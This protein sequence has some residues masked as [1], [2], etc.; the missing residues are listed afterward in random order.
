MEPFG[1]DKLPEVVR[2]LL[3]K[4]EHLEELLLKLHYGQ[5]VT[6]KF[7]SVKEAAAYLQISVPALYSL[8]SRRQ[9][10]VN[11]PGKRLYFLT[12]ELDE[13]IK[14]GKLKTIDEIDREAPANFRSNRR[15]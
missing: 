9:I 13:W 4:V 12:T 5:G 10:P 2:Q 6:N 1:F 15:K 11:K 14:A 3:E 8:V 7:L